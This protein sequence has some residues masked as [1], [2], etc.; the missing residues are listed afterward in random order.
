MAAGRLP[1]FVCRDRALRAFNQLREDPQT[2][3][4]MEYA[5]CRSG[6]DAHLSTKTGISV[7][8]PRKTP[9]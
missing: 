3:S 8:K 2:P 9:T 5:G 1:L 4:L 6:L 7:L